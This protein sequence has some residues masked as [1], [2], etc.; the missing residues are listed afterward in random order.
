MS[1][2]PG[3]TA[4]AFDWNQAH[5]TYRRPLPHVVQD[6]V[7]YFVTFRLADSIP[8]IKLA[9]WQHELDRWL[10]MNPLPH[11]PAQHDE[12]AE[13]GYR[14]I[15]RWLDRGEGSCL[16]A[17]Q[18]VQRQLADCI[19]LRD[20]VDHLLGDYTIMP[21]HVHALVQPLPG[22]PL[23]SI[24]EGWRSSSTHQINKLCRRRGQL[25][26]QDGFDHIVRNDHA[27]ARIRCY[28]R[29]NG[30]HLP[31]GKSFYACGSLFQQ[32]SPK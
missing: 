11:T 19:L 8:R 22:K 20:G 25:W 28:I 26:Q 13:L 17:S 14:R 9:Q 5:L 15:E 7:I 31:E 23:K 4:P 10:A 21:N 16:L 1:R 30:Q 3:A 32:Q 24:L 29:D 18:I 6:A 12:Y 2:L 27:L